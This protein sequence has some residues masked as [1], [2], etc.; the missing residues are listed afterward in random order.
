MKCRNNI[1]KYNK[2]RG[3]TREVMS[4]SR[5]ESAR[6]RPVSINE[7]TPSSAL[8]LKKTKYQGYFPP[9]T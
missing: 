2:K 3:V 7:N 8:L 9:N 6:K 1:L 5:A 4:P